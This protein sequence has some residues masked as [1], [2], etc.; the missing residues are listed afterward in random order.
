MAREHEGRELPD[1]ELA[2]LLS[3]FGWLLELP[4][5]AHADQPVPAQVVGLHS[6]TVVDH[7]DEGVRNG[8]VGRQNHVD[9]RRAGI[10]GIR[11]QLLDR[12]V[13]AG[14]ETLGEELDNAI[15]DADRDLAGLLPSADE[16]KARK[17]NHRGLGDGSDVH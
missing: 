5:V 14:V 17:V 1:P 6:R 11:D 2:N 9:I 4:L 12:L 10:E 8:T 16:G 13:W 7:S 15:A 3:P